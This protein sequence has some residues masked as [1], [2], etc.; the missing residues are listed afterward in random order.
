[1][2]R[3][4]TTFHQIHR[5]CNQLTSFGKCK[6]QSIYLIHRHTISPHILLKMQTQIF[7]LHCACNKTASINTT[8]FIYLIKWQCRVRRS[9]NNTNFKKYLFIMNIFVTHGSCPS[10]IT[11]SVTQTS[12]VVTGNTVST[13]SCTLLTTV[14]TVPSLATF[15]LQHAKKYI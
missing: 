7:S 10:S 2:F 1:M 4:T 6:L 15:Y 13:V 3:S 5:S 11:P 12:H 14:D 9:G 8:Q